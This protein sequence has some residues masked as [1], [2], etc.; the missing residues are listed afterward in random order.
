MASPYWPLFDLT[1]RTSLLTLTYP[2]DEMLFGLA[3]KTGDLFGSGESQF[4]LDWTSEPSPVRELH[5]L[6]YWWR[7]RAEVTPEHFDLPMAVVVDGEAVGIQQL[8]AR[9]FARTRSVTTGSWLR[10]SFQG[11]GLG[12][13][14]RRAILCLAFDGLGASEAHSSAFETN[15]ASLAVSR[16]LGYEPN[17]EQV[18]LRGEVPARSLGFRMTRERFAAIPTGDIEIAGLE[19]CLAMLGLEPHPPAPGGAGAP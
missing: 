12:K 3:T 18:A 4:K 11:R 19:P 16:S 2:D 14:M 13:E 7:V 10:R 9:S 5:S 15:Q 17:G 8:M 1:V 6:Q